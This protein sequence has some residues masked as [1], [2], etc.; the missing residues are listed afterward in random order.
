MMKVV[1]DTFATSTIRFNSIDGISNFINSAQLLLDPKTYQMVQPAK[2]YHL[3][4]AVYYISANGDSI[5]AEL[6]V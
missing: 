5:L 6:A 2:K 4:M 3:Q 1:N